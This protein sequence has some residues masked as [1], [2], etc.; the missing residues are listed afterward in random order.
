MRFAWS[1]LLCL[2]LALLSLNASA[3]TIVVTTPDLGDITKQIASPNDEVIVLA[4]GTQDPHFVDAQP[5]LV[6]DLNRADLLIY[7]GMELE[8]GWLPVLLTSAAN[9]DIQAG[10]KGHLNCA[11]AVDEP[12]E[13]P[14]NNSRELGDVHPDGNPHYMIDPYNGRKVSRIIA[15]KLVELNPD[16]AQTYADNL[17]AFLIELDEHIVK[18][19]ALMDEHQGTHILTYHRDWSYLAQWLGL[20]LAGEIEPVPGVPPSPSHLAEVIEKHKNGKA[21]VIIAAPWDEKKAPQKVADELG[22]SLVVLPSQPGALDTSG[23]IQMIDTLITSL[24][25]AI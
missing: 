4:S 7:T 22:I 15:G 17:K 12:L 24:H 11:V 9:A 16:E 2:S 5:G 18:W 14:S 20:T 10:K 6:V 23:Y 3:L 13:V 8:V 1:M 25:E 19:E 21:K